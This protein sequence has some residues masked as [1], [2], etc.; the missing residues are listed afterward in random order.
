[1]LF[2]LVQQRVRA[3]LSQETENKERRTVEEAEPLLRAMYHF[4][5]WSDLYS[6]AT[7][8]EREDPR[9]YWPFGFPRDFLIYCRHFA[10]D[11]LH[12]HFP[13]RHR[14][15]QPSSTFQTCSP[16][17]AVTQGIEGTACDP[18]QPPNDDVCEFIPQK[19]VY[20]TASRLAA[21]R[22]AVRHLFTQPPTKRPKP[23][24]QRSPVELYPQ[25]K[26]SVGSVG[27]AMFVI[28]SFVS[29]YSS[30]KRSLNSCYR[31]GRKIIAHIFGSRR[32]KII[33]PYFKGLIACVPQP[34]PP[35]SSIQV[36]RLS[37][38]IIRKLHSQ[39]LGHCWRVSQ[40]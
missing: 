4:R 31:D 13:Y 24:N 2:V 6:D 38:P 29:G 19:R 12:K 7:A 9:L 18:P 21:S 22:D 28:R 27:M 10:N 40:G 8:E 5:T 26:C 20:F 15:H 32:H 36:M 23:E 14:P 37:N 11:L 39:T 16:L 33:F 34:S 3:N 25:I 35:S 30:C 17:Y 1:M